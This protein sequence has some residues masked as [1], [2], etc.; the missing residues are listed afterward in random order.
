MYTHSLFCYVCVQ[1]KQGDGVEFSNFFERFI[2]D[3]E[4][5]VEVRLPP[6]Y[7]PAPT[8]EQVMVKYATS[9]IQIKTDNVGEVTNALERMQISQPS[10]SNESMLN[11]MKKTLNCLH[12]MLNCEF[13]DIKQQALIAMSQMAHA[14]IEMAT[15]IAQDKDIQVSLK[16]FVDTNFGKIEQDIYDLAIRLLSIK[17]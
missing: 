12:R 11:E 4:T 5:Q 1:L 2:K 15:A 9:K 16:E 14:S 6:H 7:I 3:L 10:V 13:Q 8:Q 17:N